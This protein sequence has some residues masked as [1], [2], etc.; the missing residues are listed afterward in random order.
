MTLSLRN[1]FSAA[2]N[3]AG[4]ITTVQSK[5]SPGLESGAGTFSWAQGW[6]VVNVKSQHI[7][8]VLVK[9]FPDPPPA[10]LYRSICVSHVLYPD[11]PFN[12]PPDCINIKPDFVWYVYMKRWCRKSSL[13]YSVG[14]FEDLRWS[15][16]HTGM[17]LSAPSGLKLDQR[18][19]SLTIWQKHLVQVSF[20]A[21]KLTESLNMRHYQHC[22]KITTF[23]VEVELKSTEIKEMNMCIS[24]M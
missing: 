6:D 14:I 11:F 24:F 12:L 8:F 22:K 7:I 13:F 18:V 3:S 5:T 10:S 19:S 16:T 21:F 20:A 9:P 1:S 15:Q 23:Q 4:G 2:W 17:S